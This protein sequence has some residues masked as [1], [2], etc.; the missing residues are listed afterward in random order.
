MNSNPHIRVLQMAD[1]V[2]G[3]AGF[4]LE[5]LSSVASDE[6]SLAFGMKEDLKKLRETTAILKA[7]LLDAEKKQE[8]DEHLRM[9]LTRLKVVF[10][11][12]VDVLDE[13]E[14]EVLRREVVKEY[15]SFGRQV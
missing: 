4:V 15:G 6:I 12:A 14:C 1:L 5:K 2:F 10:D 3:V 7:M 9:S 8:H 13:F 11:D